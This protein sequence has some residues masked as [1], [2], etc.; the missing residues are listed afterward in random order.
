M[1]FYYSGNLQFMLIDVYTSP[2]VSTWEKRR[3]SKKIRLLCTYV[4]LNNIYH[5]TDKN[6]Y[7]KI[8]HVAAV[9]QWNINQDS[10]KLN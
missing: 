7:D 8:L 6:N 10:K 4:V 3:I 5:K 1:L 9:L 2:S